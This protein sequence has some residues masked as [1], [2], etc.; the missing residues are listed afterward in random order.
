M[1]PHREGGESALAGQQP[2][3]PASGLMLPDPQC[4]ATSSFGFPHSTPK[5]IPRVSDTTEG[6]VEYHVTCHEVMQRALGHPGL[7]WYYLI[8]ILL[9]LSLI[10]FTA[11]VGYNARDDVYLWVFVVE[12][13]LTTLMCIEA[14]IRSWLLGCKRCWRSVWHVMDCTLCIAC[15]LVLIAYVEL[16][17]D[18]EDGWEQMLLA[19]RFVMQGVRCIVMLRRHR[20]AVRL[21]AGEHRVILPRS[22]RTSPPGSSTLPSSFFTARPS[23]T[24]PA[25]GTSLFSEGTSYP[26]ER[27]PVYGSLGSVSALALFGKQGGDYLR[28]DSPKLTEPATSRDTS[29]CFGSPPN[30]KMHRAHRYLSSHRGSAAGSR[31]PPP[32]AR[33]PPPTS[34]RTPPPCASAA[35]PTERAALIAS[36]QRVFGQSAPAA[37]P[38]GSP[39]CPAPLGPGSSVPAD[40]LD[41]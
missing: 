10:V 24:S 37:R 20:D 22:S 23:D 18:V 26:P 40:T 15:V 8:C 12:I 35:D 31:T 16:S 6:T 28:V 1:Q 38:V 4:P 32:G 39:L 33:T 13:A 9:T 30:R 36:S 19:L 41:V 11:V 3:S 21:Q 34:S 27:N 7:R 5:S 14:G 29:P 2:Q 25:F 17:L